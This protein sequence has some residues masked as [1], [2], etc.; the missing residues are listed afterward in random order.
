[1]N[2][3]GQIAIFVIV[4]LVIVGVIVVVFAYPKLSTLIAPREINPE[5]Y[6]RSC[7]EPD[8]KST[9]DLLAKQGG[10]ENPVG[11][12]S[13]L[14]TKVKYLCYTSGYYKT[15]V[16][17]QPLLITQ[18]NKEASRMLT[19]RANQCARN[20]IT[21][22]EKR[23]YSVSSSTITSNIS[24]AS[25]KIKIDFYAP[26][27]VTKEDYS[28][29]F[30]S[31][32]A[33]VDSEMYNLLSIATSILDYETTYGDSATEL[34]LNYYPNLKIEKIKL[35]D[36]VKVYKLTDVVTKEIFQ[37]ATRSLVWPPGYGLE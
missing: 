30:D 4:A 35:E 34:Y 1:M 13:Y 33:S 19:S 6:L 18:F 17:Q 14:D 37:F 10:E 22:Y 27:T 16:V 9:I 5:E 29:S 31:F 8:V 7:L 32:D 25:G 15:C 3:G 23:G 36:G 21:E 2:K 20:L 26:M 28:K 11:F 24:L 12:I